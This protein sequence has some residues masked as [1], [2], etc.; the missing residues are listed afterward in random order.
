M[1][2]GWDPYFI[3]GS[4]TYGN[5]YGHHKVQLDNAF[6]ANDRSGPNYDEDKPN[7]YNPRL[8]V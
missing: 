1:G 7:A 4:S 3:Y 5:P 6:R 8:I 2:D